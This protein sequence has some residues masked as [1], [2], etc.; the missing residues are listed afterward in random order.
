[1]KITYLKIRNLFGIK[2][3]EQNGENVELSGTNGVGK[4]SVI[5][6]IRYALT[7][8][9][10]RNIIVRQ[11][12][13]EGEIL[14][15]T[16]TGLKINRIKRNDTTDYKSVKN[17]GKEVK[18]PE[19]FLG[20][21]FSSLQLNPVEFMEMPAREQNRA[22]LDMIDYQWSLDNIKEWFGEIPSWVDYNQS[23]LGVLADIQ[24]EKGDYFLKRQDVN[25]DIRNKK[26]FVDDILGTLP[27]GYNADEWENVS[28]GE[29]YKQIER[30]QYDNSQIEKAKTMLANS[31]NKKR[32]IDADREIELS[33]LD[34]TFAAEEKRLSD[35]I[36]NLQNQ[37]KEAQTALGALGEQKAGKIE[38]IN[39]NHDKAIAE[40]DKEIAE[41][42]KYR[43]VDPKDCSD[44]QREV[45]NIEKMKAY[46]NEYKR[47]KILELEVEDLQEV[48]NNYTRL[49]EKARSLPAEILAQSDIPIE[50]LS[51]DVAKGIPLINGLPVSNLSDGEKLD[52]CVDVALSNASGLQ[53]ILVDGVERLATPVRERLYSKCKDKGVQFIAT[54]TTDSDTLQV[55]TI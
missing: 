43:D 18:S 20:G 36:V 9:S 7:N 24:S 48:S 14:V 23:I 3:Y 17:G 28:T 26:A 38:V 49:I 5:D 51:I 2:E 50:G 32:S 8:K 53:F 12:E 35:L 47:M 37:I 31:D 13:S 10:G 6:A 34:R 54:R 44:L 22:I 1:M 39:A 40:F 46:V 4:S 15:E 30:I 42:A 27:V 21:L 55:A 52:L 19:A 25:R 41:Y 16:D 11:G 29:I 45:E 33:A